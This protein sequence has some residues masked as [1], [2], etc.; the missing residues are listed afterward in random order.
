M[1]A[2]AELLASQ[3]HGG[4]TGQY[5][6][7]VIVIIGAPSDYIAWQEAGSGTDLKHSVLPG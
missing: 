3:A 2:G 6:R 5:A 4:P 7:E 1:P